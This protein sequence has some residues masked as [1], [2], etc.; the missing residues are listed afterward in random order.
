[1]NPR[2]IFDGIFGVAILSAMLLLAAL[3][4]SV[5]VQRAMMEKFHYS[6]D[7][8]PVWAA[9][10]MVPSMYN[11]E[12]ESVIVWEV[13]DSE[14][15]EGIKTWPH[16]PFHDVGQSP[17]GNALPPGISSTSSIE[18]PTTRLTSRY[19]GATLTTDLKVSVKGEN[20]FVV[21]EIT[22]EFTHD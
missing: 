10:Q 18:A 6:G 1:M 20:G 7:S 14:K 15:S 5:S 22:S 12:N 9:L 19:R 21:S 2:K 4:W 3:P 16:H 13:T 8:F 11:F 17:E